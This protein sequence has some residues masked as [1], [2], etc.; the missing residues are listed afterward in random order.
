MNKFRID[1]SEKARIIGLHENAT[2]KQYLS[3]QDK[4]KLY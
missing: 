4:G 1:E 3:E 2:K